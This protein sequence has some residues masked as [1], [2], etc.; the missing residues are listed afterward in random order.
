MQK[1]AGNVLRFRSADKLN[2][3]YV[4]PTWSNE[5][6]VGGSL[7]GSWDPVLVPEIKTGYNWHQVGGG[8]T[9]KI[10]HAFKNIIMV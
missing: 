3:D 9:A 8:A 6:E 4:H 1:H 2:V 5:V 7:D 10:L